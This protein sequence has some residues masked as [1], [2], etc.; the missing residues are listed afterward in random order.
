MVQDE[1]VNFIPKTEK[2][3]MI[4]TQTQVDPEDPAFLHPSK[5][6]GSVY[7]KEGKKPNALPRNNVWTFAQDGDKY[8]RV[9]ARPEP[10]RRTLPL[11]KLVENSCIVICCSG[12]GISTCFNE[13]GDFVGTRIILRRAS[14]SRKADIVRRGLDLC[15]L[16][17]RCARRRHSAGRHCFQ[18]LF[19]A[20]GLPFPFEQTNC[21]F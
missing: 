11:K 4:F 21:F 10:K 19:F 7:E 1:H 18:S 9:V 20:V 12:G 14:S 17:I 8:R 6:V 16:Q 3:A 5:P 13:K 15:F 2:L